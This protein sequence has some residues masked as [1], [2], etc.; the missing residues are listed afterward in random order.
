MIEF[1]TESQIPDDFSG[2][3][4]VISANKTFHMK[5]GELHREDG[6]ALTGIDG[7][8]WWFYK[9]KPHR[10]DGPCLVQPHGKDLFAL[11]GKAFTETQFWQQSE[12][13]EAKLKRICD[14]DS[15]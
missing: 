14:A 13:L 3:C 9:S 11:H 15:E 7:T 1:G 5:N 2:V 8:V 4:F 10:L 6:P 12:V